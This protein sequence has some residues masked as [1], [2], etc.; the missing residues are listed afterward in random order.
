MKTNDTALRNR[1]LL[2]NRK[3]YC[4]A[5]R[6]FVHHRLRAPVNLIVLMHARS[7]T[8]CDATP[9]D[10]CSVMYVDGARL[11]STSSRPSLLVLCCDAP[12][13]RTPSR[14]GKRK[15][16]RSCIPFGN[17]R[18]HAASQWPSC[19]ASTRMYSPCNHARL[20]Q[21]HSPYD[22]CRCAAYHSCQ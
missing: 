2:G 17:I 22:D 14:S 8:S 3:I 20:G 1:S 15:I 11:A 5:L 9:Q 7:V 12:L 18:L 4:V 6:L 21:L 19:S 16:L 13:L 10:E